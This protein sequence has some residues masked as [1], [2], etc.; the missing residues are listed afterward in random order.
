MDYTLGEDVLQCC[1]LG[2]PEANAEAQ[3]VFNR[4]GEY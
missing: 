1:M 4:H 2:P 3:S